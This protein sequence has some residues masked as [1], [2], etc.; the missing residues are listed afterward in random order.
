[1]YLKS[2]TLRGFKSFASTTTMRFEPGI[3]C[4]VGPNG[5]GK[6]NVVDALAWVMGEQGAKNMRGGAMADVIFAGTAQRQALGRAEV[7]LCIDNSDGALPIE[8]REVTISRT[9]FKSGGSEYAIN[10]TSC[11]L[12]DIQELLS[13]TGM[14]KEMHVII[15]QGKLDEVLTSTPEDRRGFIEEAAGLLKHRK[16][17]EKAL[18]K[19]DS[20][21]GSLT[22]IED[23]TVELRRQM[24]PLARQA[25][26]AR[27]AGIVQAELRDAKARLLA[28]DL[29][30]QQARLA[31]QSV[32]EKQISAARSENSTRMQE[33]KS[34]L[35]ELER[36]V[37]RSRPETA[38]LAERS[39]NLN[40]LAERY[41]SLGELARERL[42]S[43]VQTGNAEYRGE[44]PSDIRERARRARD[45]ET[46]LTS[47]V[48]DAVAEL[49]IHVALRERLEESERELGKQ[50]AD[51]SG[52]IAKNREQEVLNQGKISTA[53][54]R[55]ES[56]SGELE[57]ISTL[58]KS[59]QARAEAAAAESSTLE[60]RLEIY[61]QKETPRE[62]QELTERLSRAQELLVELRKKEQEAREDLASLSAKV[63]VLALSLEPQDA[64]AWVLEH[65]ED[66]IRPLA[67]ELTVAP[68]WESALEA[69]LAGAAGGVV[70]ADRSRA[71]ELLGGVR[72]SD[73]G[74]IVMTVVAETSAATVEYL[75]MQAQMA[76]RVVKE[77]GKPAD[78][79]VCA[80]DVIS[81]SADVLAAIWPWLAGTVLA[82]DLGTADELSR[83]GA[84]RVVTA[85]GDTVTTHLIMGG[86]ESASIL[87]RKNSH[88]E[89][90][91]AVSKVNQALEKLQNHIERTDS[92]VSLLSAKC[93]EID[94]ER[95]QAAAHYAEQKAQL[96]YNKKVEQTVLAE[97]RRNCDRRNAIE[98]ELERRNAEL[99]QLHE[100]RLPQQ[101]SEA[102]SHLARIQESVGAAHESTRLERQ[103]EMEAR[104]ALRT[105][106]E[107]LRSVSGKSDALL[108][109]AGAVEERLDRAKRAA[110][111][112]EGASRI[113]AEV[114]EDSARGFAAVQRLRESVT[115]ERVSLQVDQDVVELQLRECRRLL[116]ELQAEATKLANSL[117]H[118]ELIQAEHR[119]RYEQLGARAIEELSMGPDALIEEYGPLLPVPTDSG[120]V[121]YVRQDQEKR[122][123]K[124]ER[125]IARLGKI[126]PLAL[127]E[128]AAL[129]ERQRYLTDQLGD[130]KRSREDLL[131]IVKDVD[132]HVHNVLTDAL[133]DVSQKFTEVFSMVFPGGEGRLILT[134]PQSPL[135]TGIEIEARPAGKRV[136]RLSLL[137]GGERSLTALAFLVAIFMARPSPFYV[138]DEVEAALDDTNLSRL[139][140]IFRELQEN[141]QLLVITHQ[142]RTM[143]IADTL[144]G[145]AMQDSGVSSVISQRLTDLTGAL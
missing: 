31:S 2:L 53:Q 139:L 59:E 27:K 99:A 32:T 34:A 79:A 55:I 1:M 44:H 138:M 69:S 14:G 122:L 83:A 4:I 137:S 120:E 97:L 92:E 5:S 43:L 73:A 23:L 112:R 24:G 48:R 95:V 89:A 26:A 117:H 64:T 104:L 41:R 143:E 145:I 93:Q 126:N 88:E 16:R 8:Y 19:L 21:Q 37:A 86:D 28:D 107:R 98:K 123:E 56:L 106:E 13:D 109:Q 33:T 22:R 105:A 78:V 130:L 3:N 87:A 135:T 132:H 66:T 85:D 113:A 121:P 128:H 114:A 17:K 67:G 45:E 60:R 119:L 111:R 94:D 124:A 80:V 125:T 116:E 141:S 25:D 102:T 49:E 42:R 51:L 7:S 30:Q 129:E 70:L 35:R 46:R 10:G 6:S 103:R 84:P 90:V 11:R 40:S 75:D 36:A 58:R 61:E 15:G 133:D 144:Y 12:L 50:V 100:L 63:E 101:P 91:R 118:S 77:L 127:E 136:K 20:M 110:E 39:A 9:L 131:G 18:R 52:Q 96:R 81:A 38:Q 62:Y 115:Q 47:S 74:H 72:D 65:R 71:I 82:S 134:D 108:H 140:S 76:S 142:K 29:A 54:A 57:R 68:G